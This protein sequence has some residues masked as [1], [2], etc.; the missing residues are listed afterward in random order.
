MKPE[1]IMGGEEEMMYSRGCL[2]EDDAGEVR[3]D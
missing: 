3:V 2:I 1:Y